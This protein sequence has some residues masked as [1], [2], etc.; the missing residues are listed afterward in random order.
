MINN[1]AAKA[2][3]GYTQGDDIAHTFTFLDEAGAAISVSGWVWTMVITKCNGDAVAT[4]TNASGITFDSANV[5]R[6]TLA[7]AIAISD[8]LIDANYTLAAVA[9]GKRRTYLF[10]QFKKQKI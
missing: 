8:N 1:T 4:Y 2:D 3:I 5:L 6:V 7:N 10:G 9:S